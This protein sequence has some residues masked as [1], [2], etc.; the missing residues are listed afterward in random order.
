M[1][2]LFNFLKLNFLE[3]LAVYLG[4]LRSSASLRSASRKFSVEEVEVMDF[5]FLF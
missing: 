5:N 1:S 3:G 4:I 2:F